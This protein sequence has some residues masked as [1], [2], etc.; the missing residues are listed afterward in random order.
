MM[1]I[2]DLRHFLDEEGEIP[3]ELPGPALE[4]ALFLGSIAAWVTSRECRDPYCEDA[5]TN[6]PCRR[7]PR[8]RRC[9]GTIVAWLDSD[10]ATIVWQ[11]LNCGDRGT[12]TGWEGT[13]WDR[14]PDEVHP[15]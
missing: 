4:M 11:C 15:V 5:W 3:D 9:R 13:D 1:W 14:R 8:R 6:V 10:G 12:I 7:R 2:S